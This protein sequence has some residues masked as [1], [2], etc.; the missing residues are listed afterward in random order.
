[1]E[2]DVPAVRARDNVETRDSL[3]IGGCLCV[4]ATRTAGLDLR[5]GR[6]RMWEAMPSAT[7]YGRCRGRDVTDFTELQGSSQ[8]YLDR[9][10][11]AIVISICSSKYLIDWV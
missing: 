11:H 7:L 9:V 10:R 2:C 4:L 6:A 5:G 8:N 3:G 1:M